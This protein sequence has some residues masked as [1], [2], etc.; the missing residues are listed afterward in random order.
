MKRHLKKGASLVTALAVVAA[1]SVSAFASEAPVPEKDG[2]APE[3]DSTW[4][5]LFRYFDP[6]GFEALPVEIQ[7]Q[8]DAAL[9]DTQTSV[10]AENT[11][12]AMS[13]AETTV[14]ATGY[15]YTDTDSITP[16]SRKTDIAGLLNL[17]LG[18]SSTETE[19]EYTAGLFC[20]KTCPWMYC[21]VTIYD[22]ETGEYIDFD[23]SSETD[24]AKVCSVDGT[25]IRLQSNHEYKVKAFGNVRPP[26]GYFLSN[27][28]Y[29][30]T[31]KETK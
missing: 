3:A 22:G 6:E 19:I 13:D 27:P 15:L 5:D 10:G 14:S 23:R 16:E 28:L 12:S 1:L 9:L 31:M 8:Y 11:T 4:G 20:T 7:D 26:E 29:V 2:F 21:S 25:F 24:G 30:E 17:T 18:V